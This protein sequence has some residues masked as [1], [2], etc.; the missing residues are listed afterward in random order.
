M[1]AHISL[2]CWLH[3]GYFIFIKIHWMFLRGCLMCK[4]KF[5]S[6]L[7]SFI[8]FTSSFSS[9]WGRQSTWSK[10]E[11]VFRML[12][13]RIFY[14]PF[15]IFLVHFGQHFIHWYPVHVVPDIHI[16]WMEA[17]VCNR[18]WSPPWKKFTFWRCFFIS[19]TVFT[20]HQALQSCLQSVCR[21]AAE[22]H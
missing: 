11:Q 7:T 9:R 18:R 16:R 20:L 8:C 1:V 4:K 17:P 19:S 6:L 21:W 2:S 15:Q 22:D 3:Q 14:F 13:T 10:I 5:F 12:L